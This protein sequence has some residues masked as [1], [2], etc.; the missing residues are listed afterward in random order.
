MPSE[1][2]LQYMWVK[3]VQGGSNPCPVYCQSVTILIHVQ[4]KL[5]DSGVPVT[6]S[7]NI[8][9]GNAATLQERAV[10]GCG[11]YNAEEVINLGCTIIY[12]ILQYRTAW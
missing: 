5:L 7:K 8:P 12:C 4:N 1:L 9:I 3:D 6:F 11:L 2:L 10:S